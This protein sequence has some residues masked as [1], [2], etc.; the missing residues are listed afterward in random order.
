M[1]YLFTPDLE[2]GNAL[3]DQEHK[4]LIQAINGLLDACARGVGRTQLQRTAI[5]LQDYTTKHFSDEETLQQESCYP[6]FS[7]HHQYHEDFKQVVADLMGRLNQEGPTLPLV[8]EVNTALA[9]WLI[10]HIKSQDKKVA[11][12]IQ[13]QSR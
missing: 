6:D 2:T 7:N 9:D 12:H 1:A 10:N 3:I 4:Q 5:F 13:A 8:N 11:A